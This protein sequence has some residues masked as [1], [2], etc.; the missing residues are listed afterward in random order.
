[1]PEEGVGEPHLEK[2]VGQPE[3]EREEDREDDGALDL[4]EH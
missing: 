1:M 3:H 4:G 2:R